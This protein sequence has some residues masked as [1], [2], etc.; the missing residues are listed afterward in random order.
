MSSQLCHL[1]IIFNL[2]FIALLWSCLEKKQNKRLNHYPFFVNPFR[3]QPEPVFA[4]ESEEDEEADKEP[5]W[6]KRKI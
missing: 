3:T 1:V 2:K 4:E 6:K 5:E